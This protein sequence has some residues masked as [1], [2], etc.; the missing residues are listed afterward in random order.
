MRNKQLLNGWWDYRIADGVYVKKQ[1]PYSDP[2]VGFAECRR[3][4]TRQKQDG[5]AFLNLDG[6]TYSGE[7]TLN[8]VSLGVMQPYSHYVY[9]ITDLIQ[10]EN[11]LSVVISDTQVVFGPA[12]G[13]EN[14][15]GII[16]DVYV[17]YT[18]DAIIK[19]V[20]WKA[21][22]NGNCQILV[23]ADEGEIQAELLDPFGR[24]A[25]EGPS[26]DVTVAQP[27]LWSPEHPYLYTLCVKLI[28]EGIV[29]DENQQRVGIKEL[30]ADGRRFRLNG[31]PIF[32]VGVNR[33]DTWGD[34]GHIL[35]EEQMW[36]DMRMIKDA[37][38]NYVRLVHYPHHKKI[39]DIADELGL[40]V[41]EEPGLWWSD[42]KN[43][44]IVEGSLE[45]LRRTVL[46]DRNHVSVGFWLSF[47]E[48]IFTPEFLRAS[49]ETCR[50]CDDT[51]M[52][53]G[54]NCMDIPMTKKYFAECGFDF[55]TMHPYAPTTDRMIESAAELNDKPLLLTEW[56]GYYVYENPHLFKMFVEEQIKMWQNPKDKPIITGAAIWVWAEMFEFNRAYPACIDGVLEEGMVDR[57]RNPKSTLKVFKEMYAKVNEK[58]KQHK[59]LQVLELPIGEGFYR[60]LDLAGV[61][62]GQE[63]AWNRMMEHALTPIPRYVMKE[64]RQRVINDGPMLPQEVKNVGE[65]PADLLI[66][67]V[68]LNPEG[69][70]RVLLHTD[71]K[72]L[73][74]FGNVSMPKGFPIEGA[75]GEIVAVYEIE[76]KDGH[77]EEFV[78]HN[79]QEIT[80]ACA[81]FGPSRINPRASKAPRALQFIHDMDREHYV[82]NRYRLPLSGPAISLTIRVVTDGYDLLTYGI[83]EEVIMPK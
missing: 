3:Q 28:K 2:P 57:F 17:E 79:G 13:W 29:V 72:A 33:H 32:L 54:A 5:R 6:I 60:P 65:M 82:V 41:S 78:M 20:I 47:N 34:Q 75:Y 21:R 53:S 30:T 59:K 40:L 45:V 69:T 71:A 39:L 44:E 58:P 7:V 80:T 55:Y 52:V 76:Y 50:A 83:T 15:S 56:G 25:Y 31:E 49:A 66:R 61:G 8:G 63:A 38:A 73:H 51:R 67:P 46:R 12:E 43:P 18:E 62:E 27:Y 26:G 1:I 19:D 68:V 22:I 81:W 37:G 10:E 74:I 14:Y 64:R 11:D 9:E 48:C 4:F 16:R 36:Q 77:K 23:E 35:T 70:L 24:I 42:M